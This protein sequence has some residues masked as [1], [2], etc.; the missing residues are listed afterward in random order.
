M[1]KC[2]IGK[3]NL[4]T[5]TLIACSHFSYSQ[6][7]TPEE[8]PFIPGNLIVQVAENAN[9]H[10]IVAGI[11]AQ[12]NFKVDR[13]LASHMRA[14]LIEFD[15]FSLSQMDA[16][17]MVNRLPGITLAQNN[18]LVE[19]RETI[20]DDPQFNQQWHHKNTGQSGGTAGADIKTTEAWDIT[21]GGKN[22]LGHDIVVCILEGVDFSH[23][24]LINNHWTNPFEIPGNGI[25]D[26]GNG[27]IDDIH[28]WNV[29]NNSGTLTG[30]GIQTGHGTNVAGMIGAK[31]DNSLGVVGANWDVKMMNVVGYNVNTEASVVAAYNYPLSL[32]KKYNETN[33]AQ[34]AFVVATNASWGIDN[35]NPNNYPI[36]CQFYDTLG[37][38]GI[39]NCGATTNS[40][41]N[42]D[43]N[44]DMPTA[45]SSTYMVGIGRSG[46]NDNIAGGYGVTT[47]DFA[48]PGINVRTT[49]NGNNYTTT[50]GTSFASPLT[51]GVIALLYAIP[52]P[53]FMNMVLNDPQLAAD[54]VFNSLMNGLDLK[55]N[56][57]N[58]YIGGGRL[59]AK[60]SMDI[61]ME[62]TCGTC[63]AP[64]NIEVIN[65]TE[66]SASVSF[67]Q[68]DDSNIYFLYLREE[69][70]TTWEEYFTLGT[71][72]NLTGLSECTAYEYY[73][74][75]HCPGDEISNATAIM[76]FNTSGCGSCVDLTY[77]ESEA[78]S[79]SM[80]FVIHSPVNIAGEISSYTETNNW[81]GAI[82]NGYIYGD[83]V[84]VDDGTANGELGCAALINGAQLSGKIAVAVR[85]TC[86][87]SEKAVNAQ[88]A[89]AIGLIIINNQGGGLA[90]LGAGTGSGSVTIPVIMISQ[91]DGAGLLAE[92]TGG[93]SATGLLGVQH[94][95][96]E[97]FE[98]NGVL[99]VSGDDNGYR[100]PDNVLI[101]IEIGENVDFTMIPGFDGQELEAT[102]RIWVDMNQDGDFDV[103]EL[104][105]D[106]SGTSFG[107][108]TGSFT[109]PASAFPGS[110]RLRVQFAY[111]GYGSAGLPDV[112]GEFTSGEVE[113][114]CI[115][116]IQNEICNMDVIS[117][118]NNP[119][120]NEVQDG[121]IAVNVSGGDPGY[122]YTWNNGAG[123][124]DNISSLSAG[125][126][127]LIVT[128]NSGCDTIIRYELSNATNILITETITHPACESIANGEITVEATGG[129]GITFEWTGGPS[130][131][132]YS[133][134]NAGVIE[135]V[136]TDDQGCKSSKLF[137]LTYDTKIVFEVVTTHPTCADSEDGS[138]NVTATGAPG[139]SYQWDN[140][141]A[142]NTYTGLNNGNYTVTATSSNG[143]IAEHTYMLTATPEVVTA[144]F[145]FTS[146][147]LVVNF[148][149]TSVNGVTYE[150]DFGDSNSSTDFEPVHTYASHGTYTVCLTTSG[151]CESTT[152]CDEIV[153]HDSS[154]GLGEWHTSHSFTIY[155]NPASYEVN[156]ETTMSHVHSI[157][158]V[159][160]TGQ[161]VSSQKITAGTT[162]I[163]L[164]NLSEGL[165]IVNALQE[166]GSVVFTDKLI[167]RK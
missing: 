38:Y 132:T 92:L 102:T 67:E 105:Y 11:P 21:T 19:I 143:C 28:G 160:V 36:W 22:A 145:D 131:D 163:K 27:Y 125:V 64:T 128:D 71:S 60:N 49:S 68:T 41:T 129:T 4:L 116:L 122:T 79:E 134:L 39:L 57:T 86:N 115:E 127:R 15:P 45:C 23:N 33:G 77:C 117:T 56:M 107:E 138:I 40:N 52:C 1:L 34:G 35:A 89:G 146:D 154:V 93:G 114:Y 136:A 18:H 156:F 155:P 25:D 96:I 158:L 70:E 91:A 51:A 66:T 147:E 167:I 139:I 87:F 148:T 53:N 103:S 50:T 69:G 144:G 101:P 10:K 24:D 88:N 98:L 47:I 5:L 112:C 29:G 13:L 162:I 149:N 72:I 97:S 151:D 32:R 37:K 58:Y 78:S 82:N 95:W 166:D 142:S 161:L 121:S 126:Y 108:L 26:D 130:G 153:V 85:G 2:L 75:S 124:V 113:D 8:E 109:V 120:C 165:Y 65:I 90:N 150:W 99:T 12:Y 157:E 14:W 141:P 74:E 111:Q 84:L 83:L 118:V 140:G 76:T 164:S 7:R 61:L 46:N 16:L 62:E 30:G 17:R 42:V 119:T 100:A 133:N 73:M 81:G 31:G 44:G 110:T 104:V 159:S 55:T 80:A 43:V 6:M 152:V 137:L 3:L 48:A 9:I 20:P 63:I 106:E 123:N 135:V 54:L 94:E 59:N